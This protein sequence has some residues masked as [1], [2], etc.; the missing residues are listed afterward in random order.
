MN[1]TMVMKALHDKHGLPHLPHGRYWPILIALTLLLPFA[2]ARAAG[3]TLQS[4][5]FTTLPGDGLQVQLTL[6]GQATAP[7]VFHTDNPARIALDLPGVGSALDKKQIPVNAGGAQSIQAVEASGRTRVILNLTEMMPYS[8]RTEGNNIYLTLKRGLAGPYAEVPTTRA[9]PAPT[10]DEPAPTRRAP[11]TYMEPSAYGKRVENVD[12][13]RGEHGEGRLL[14]TLSDPKTVADIREE[15]RKVIVDIPGVSLPATLA[16]R[17]DVLDFA[18]PVQ[19]IESTEEA[20]HARLTVFPVSDEYEYSSYQADK[21][22]TVEFRPLTKAEKE[23]ARKKAFAYSGEKLSLNFQDIPV[24]SVLQ[25]LADFTNL[26]IVASDSVAGNVTL[27][28]NEVPWDQALD[29]V[30]KSKGL[31]KRQEGNIIRVAP[32]DEINKH[33]KEE[34]EAQKVIEEL[35]PL[36]TEII[37]VNYTKAEDI[38]KVLIGTTE[39]TSATQNQAATIGTGGTSS[40]TSTLDVSQSILS[41]RGNVT[42][43]ERTNQLIIK[44]TARNLERVRELIRQLDIPVRQVLIESRIVIADNRFRRDLGS[45][46][47]ATS[48][49]GRAEVAAGTKS[50]GAADLLTTNLA[51]LNPHAFAGMTLLKAG[52]YLL[53]LELSAAQAEQR[54]EI[55]SNPRLITSDQTKAVI[56]QGKE[57]PYTTVTGGGGGAAAMIT[58]QFKQAVLELDVTPHITPDD[59]ILMGLLIKKDEKGEVIATPFGGQAF[60]IDKRE[61][62]TTVQVGNGET[63]VLGGVYEATKRNDVDKVPFLGDLPGIGPLFRRNHVTDNKTELLIF[64]TPKILKQQMAGR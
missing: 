45:R 19:F 26:N 60:A 63:V 52:D 50:S 34:L 8:T 38:K 62:E 2:Q 27:R 5:D 37:Q 22:L 25:I 51:A 6:S 21:V 30:L 44:D 29:L 1:T 35:E 3:N 61:I 56:K 16:R 10:A 55:L 47:A 15:G 57:I 12:F 36:R 42:V 40:T 39:R 41:N 59:N 20:G 64:I 46:L 7:R 24:R 31:G 58:V 32:T 4:I 54:A 13:R 9:M 49:P 11:D 53:D 33:E 28:L 48:I 14:V 23:E 43:D 17:L 18:T